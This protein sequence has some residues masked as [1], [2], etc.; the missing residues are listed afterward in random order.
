MFSST[1]SP[2]GR[3]PSQVDQFHFDEST[4]TVFSAKRTESL[5]SA[6]LLFRQGQL[7]G[8]LHALHAL[9]RV[10]P[11][12]PTVLYWLGR[13]LVTLQRFDEASDA[14]GMC[15]ELMSLGGIDYVSSPIHHQQEMSPS[16]QQHSTLATPSRWRTPPPTPA[17]ISVELLV[18]QALEAAGVYRAETFI[19]S[20]PING[21]GN[22][23]G[24]GG[25][26]ASSPLFIA[27]P[28]LHFTKGSAQQLL[29]SVRRVQSHRANRV[30]Q[31]QPHGL[32]ND[33]TPSSLLSSWV[34]RALTPPT[35]CRRSPTLSLNSPA[36]SSPTV[37]PPRRAF[38]EGNGRSLLS[39][40][41]IPRS[42]WERIITVVVT[43]STLLVS[44]SLSLSSWVVQLW[45][46]AVPLPERLDL[47]ERRRLTT[48]IIA[49][50]VVTTL[51]GAFLGATAASFAN[52]LHSFTVPGV[53]CRPPHTEAT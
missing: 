44:A 48:Q 47:V 22:N 17:D 31:Q 37:Y 43:I 26:D 50:C 32:S 11:H 23:G 19:Q 49:L 30:Q 21:T 29:K 27:A 28:L 6:V 33:E 7:E 10:A 12:D 40:R 45:L 52:I 24:G 41:T 4:P 8:A 38:G 53:S 16:A 34:P 25:A 1:T 9:E 3:R 14:L 20:T 36:A 35:S 18:D 46:W 13:V 2:T 5:L 51:V 39:P 42:V 15:V